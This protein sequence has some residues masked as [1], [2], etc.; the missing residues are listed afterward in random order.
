MLDTEL[1]NELRAAIN[2][3]YEDI[4]GTESYERKR[5][6]AEIDR[7]RAALDFIS[8]A[9]SGLEL[10]PV[11]PS[12]TEY[13]DDGNTLI[14]HVGPWNFLSGTGDTFLAAVEDAMKND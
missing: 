7:L 11:G 13:A 1:E 3:A 8:T 4:R 5:L 6:F 10:Y 14:R 2:P 9:D 12:D